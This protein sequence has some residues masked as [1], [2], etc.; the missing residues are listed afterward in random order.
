M[1]LSVK[2]Q[3]ELYDLIHEEVM[4]ARMIV[5]EMRFD[6]NVSI[7]EIDKILSDLCFKAPKKAVDLFNKN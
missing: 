6:E 2:K 4:Q 5:W 1:K 3:Q 7:H